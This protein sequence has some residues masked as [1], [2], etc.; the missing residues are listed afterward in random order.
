VYV[1]Q[2]IERAMHRQVYMPSQGLDLVDVFMR[3][4]MAQHQVLRRRDRQVDLRLAVE[5]RCPSTMIVH[6]RYLP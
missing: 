1:E 2:R 6:D 5:W 3:S 4:Q